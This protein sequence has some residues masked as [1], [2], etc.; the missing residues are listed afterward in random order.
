MPGRKSRS[1]VPGREPER[2]RDR[3]LRHDRPGQVVCF[4]W[5]DDPAH[6]GVVEQKPFARGREITYLPLLKGY[7]R[8]SRPP[9]R[10]GLVVGRQSKS[11]PSRGSSTDA[12]PGVPLGPRPASA[13]SAWWR[14]TG[15]RSPAD[16]R[17]GRR[18]SG[19]SVGDDRVRACVWERD[20][21]AGRRRPC[22][23]PPVSGPT[24]W[25]SAATAGASRPSMG[26]RPASGRGIPPESGA[27]GDR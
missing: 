18:I 8:P 5:V 3:S 21:E 26:T 4:E 2:R 15:P 12:Q 6:P 1:E 17:D 22:R 20:G 27:R 24:P 16:P 14:A 25:P 23:T 19:Y 10:C 11:A 9:Q 13:A 7:R